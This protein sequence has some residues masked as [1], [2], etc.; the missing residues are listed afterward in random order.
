MAEN[1]ALLVVGVLLVVLMTAGLTYYVTKSGETAPPIPNQT[2]DGEP[3]TITVRGEATKTLSPDLMNL[4]MTIETMGNDTA[5]AQA[6]SATETASVK[7]ALLSAGVAESEI[8]TVS[9]YTSPVYNDSCYSD[10]YPYYDYA[11]DGYGKEAYGASS[12]GVAYADIAPMPPYPCERECGIIGYKTT[13][14]IMVESEEID[15]GGSYIEAALE[16]TNATRIDY[17]YFTLKEETRLATDSEL[18]AAAAQ[19]AKAKAQNIASGLGARL[20]KIVSINPDY[21]YPYYPMYAYD[22]RGGTMAYDESAPTE[23]FPTDYQM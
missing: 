10:C 1:T 11:Y 16:A 15:E 14:S 8:E 23:I 19:A 17:V 9:Y 6:K 22:N 21:Y 18:Q 12:E 7:A 3:P 2:D 20:G 5:E 4:G 13:H